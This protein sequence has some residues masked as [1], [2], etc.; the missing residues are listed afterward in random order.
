LVT[1]VHFAEPDPFP[2]DNL[3]GWVLR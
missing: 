1:A 3:V 2:S